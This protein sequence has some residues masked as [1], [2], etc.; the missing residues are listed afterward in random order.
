MAMMLSGFLDADGLCSESES[1][2]TFT[3]KM[4]PSSVPEVPSAVPEVPSEPSA[5]PEVL[6]VPSAVL[7]VPS[8]APEE[9]S[10]A[11][12]EPSTAAK[13]ASALPEDE[14]QKK[15]FRQK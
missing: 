4:E 11:P 10:A 2:L 9:L 1:D 3:F 7:A 6:S 5:A 14:Q 12:A 13:G 15:H 8:L